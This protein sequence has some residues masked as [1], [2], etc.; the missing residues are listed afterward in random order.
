MVITQEWEVRSKRW[1]TRPWRCRTFICGFVMLFRAPVPRDNHSSALRCA[2]VS[3]ISS[4]IERPFQLRCAAGQATMPIGCAFD[5][6]WIA[7]RRIHGHLRL[8]VRI[9]D[10]IPA[11]AHAASAD[12]LALAGA[13]TS[14]LLC[15]FLGHGYGGPLLIG[16]IGGGRGGSRWGLRVHPN[17]FVANDIGQDAVPCFRA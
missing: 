14:F 8:I 6:R 5:V 15:F 1:S 13:A 7:A 11:P 10:R 9:G 2:L 12:A 4:A 17:H 3:S 16:V